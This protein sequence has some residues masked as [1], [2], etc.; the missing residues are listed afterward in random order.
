MKISP[1][2]VGGQGSI[3]PNEG[4]SAGADRR[5]AAIAI[6]TGQER[7]AVPETSGDAQ[8]DRTQD[9]IRRIKMRTQRSTNRHEPILAA[10][11]TPE[12]T[13]TSDIVANTEQVKAAPEATEPLSPQFAALAKAKRTLQ[14]KE[15]ELASREAAL[16]SAPV[17][18]DSYTKDQIRANALSIIREAGVTDDQLTESLLRESEDYGPGYTKLESE[19]QA[20]KQLLESQTKTSL[21]NEQAVEKQVLAQIQSDVDSLISDG[22]EFE[23][24][25]EAGYGPKV[26]ELIHKVFKTEGKILSEHEAATLMNNEIVEEGLRY[27]RLKTVQNRLKP[28]APPQQ[29]QPAKQAGPNTKIMRTLTNRDGSSSISLSKRDRAIA[30]M[31]GRLK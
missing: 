7:V 22:D 20:M 17:T 12:T 10:I 8:V 27:A 19:I 25:R 3:N 6:A 1:V 26:T 16:S 31:E 14:A 29:S 23:A 9:S 21:D 30:A 18:T 28:P 13:T 24:V 11:E 5:A 4:Q 15:R 2:A